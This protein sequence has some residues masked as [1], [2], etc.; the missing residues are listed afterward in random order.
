MSGIMKF[1]DYA[2]KLFEDF[3][4]TNAGE[5]DPMNKGEL[6]AFAATRKPDGGTDIDT[7]STAAEA[8]DVDLKEED[9]ALGGTEAAPSE[10]SDEL[11]GALVGSDEVTDPTQMNDESKKELQEAMKWWKKKS[12]KE[13]EKVAHRLYK[14]MKRKDEAK[15]K[16]AKKVGFKK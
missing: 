3:D 15:K 9:I 5:G 8:E 10:P 14:G 13:Q 7:T 6:D 12:L 4:A 2:Q 11:V 1:G 16:G